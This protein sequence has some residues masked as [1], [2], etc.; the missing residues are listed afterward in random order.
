MANFCWGFCEP[1]STPGCIDAERDAKTSEN[2]RMANGGNQGHP[3][4]CK[5]PRLQSTE[6]AIGRILDGENLPTI[7]EKWR[8]DLKQVAAGAEGLGVAMGEYHPGRGTAEEKPVGANWPTLEGANVRRLSG[9]SGGG[10]EAR[11]LEKTPGPF[12]S[13]SRNRPGQ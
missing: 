4:L 10:R 7:G 5:K 12:A 9:H 13:G 2:S 3:G 1:V 8:T 11:G 6:S